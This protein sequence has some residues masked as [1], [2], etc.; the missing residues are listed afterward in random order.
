MRRSNSSKRTRKQYLRRQK[1][2]RRSRLSTFTNFR[3]EDPPC[4]KEKK[5]FFEA[6]AKFREELKKSPNEATKK[7]LER[8]VKEQT[9]KYTDCTF[10]YKKWVADNESLDQSKAKTG[11]CQQGD[12]GC[13]DPYGHIPAMHFEKYCEINYPFEISK[14]EVDV[15]VDTVHSQSEMIAFFRE[16]PIQAAEIVHMK[17]KELF[18]RT[19]CIEIM[20][21]EFPTLHLRN[22]VTKYISN[23]NYGKEE[24]GKV[25]EEAIQDVRAFFEKYERE[26]KAV[27]PEGE[28]LYNEAM[29]L[30][31][32]DVDFS[33]SL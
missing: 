13:L 24:R 16:Y 17:V 4:S 20:R 22:I 5:A 21:T 30:V 26:I 8:T 19:V 31:N 3:G 7:E 32:Q 6:R 27:K 11:P 9:T 23:A 25:Y 12:D 33:V 15:Y 18:G 10:Q 29:L 28:S 14:Y 2:Q 1:S